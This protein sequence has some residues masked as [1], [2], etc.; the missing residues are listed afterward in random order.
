MGS[1]VPR[2]VV[3][4]M[5]RLLTIQEAYSLVQMKENASNRVYLSI[6]HHDANL[7]LDQSFHYQL[8][9]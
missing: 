1:H 3:V 2:I 8:Q 7:K 4:F 6:M 5:N 9:K